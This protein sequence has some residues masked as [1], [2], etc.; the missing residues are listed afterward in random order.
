MD[1]NKQNKDELKFNPSTPN[2]RTEAAKKLAE[3]YPEIISDGELDFV[4]LK[5]LLSDDLAINGGN[6]KYEFTWRGKRD[7]KRIADTPARNTTLVVNQGKSKDI[8]TT[9][10][11]YIEGDN[12]ETLKLLQ[13]AYGG[14]VKIIYIDPPYN[15]GNDFVYH[16]DFHDTYENY[17]KQT[18]QVDNEGNATTTNKE[19]NGRFHTDWLNMMY[20]RLKLARNLLTDDGVIMVSIGNKEQNNLEKILN[21]IFGEENRVVNFIVNSAE[22]GGQA[23]YVINGNEFVM[24]YAK[25]INKF[26][27]LKRSKDIR[28]DIVKINDE[29]YWIQEDAIRKVFGEYGNLYY[30]E[31]LDYKDQEFKDE[32]DEG[33]KNNL[34]RLVLK[35]NGMHVIGKLRK[36]SEDYS[37][38]NSVIKHLTA[39]GKRDARADF[40]FSDQDKTD[41]FD[42]PKPLSL[43][44][45]L[46]KS[47]TFGTQDDI[48][49][50]LFSGFAT[51]ARA[52]Q[53][54]N[55]DGGNR[56]FIM[57]QLPETLDKDS[58]AYKDGYKTIPDI[59][60]E[61]IRRAGEKILSEHEDLRG[62]LDVGFKV[63]ELQ[64]STI[65]Q[66]NEDPDEFENQLDLF[67]KNPFTEDSTPLQRAQEIA[68]KSGITL[69]VNPTIDK[70]IYHFK[71]DDKEVFV[72]LGVYD[73]K[74]LKK[75]DSQRQLQV[76][77]IVLRELEGGSKIKFNLLEELKQNSE[78]NNHFN[79]E[80]I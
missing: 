23:K 27:N 80:W 12:L 35:D 73:D 25:N 1:D 7:S 15:T 46:V 62:K 28:G 78:L 16:D 65:R 26:D 64:P 31:I 54:L 70:D 20:P 18:G 44:K 19:T 41:F 39:D 10:N 51:T 71:S 32:I 30:E 42:N 69:S 8:D 47:M 4:A 33:I 66:W 40:G 22:G 67:E 36:I 59:A 34:Y 79:L 58:E 53:E 24:V 6:E 21:E 43:M 3:L 75:L 49:M 5:E 13:K 55:I 77:T 45:D 38:F 37:K 61:R 50:D 72:V 17:L 9:Q 56:K 11:V 63:Y 60:Q 29:D 57:V 14:K 2:F 68:L 76:A 48:V 74:L 52:V